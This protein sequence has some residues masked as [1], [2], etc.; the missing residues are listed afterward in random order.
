MTKD[1]TKPVILWFRKDL[2]LGDNKALDAAHL[3]GRPIIPFYIR[4]PE[5]AGT[6]PLGAAQCW[7]L[8]HSLDALDS[9]L[10]ERQGR[11][12]LAGG[13]AL[14]V[15]RA[16]IGTSGADAVFWNRRYDPAGMSIDIR[17]KHELEKQAIEVQS[18]GGQL[19]HEPSRLVTGGGTPY[20]VYT[21][22]WRALENAGEP[23]PPMDAPPKLHLAQELPASDMLDS[24]GLLPKKPD[25][26]R[27]FAD[28]WT[29]G[30]QGAREKLRAFVE[31]GLAGYKENRDHP[32]RDATSMLS[33]HLALG[34]I[35]PARIWDETRGLS[36]QVPAAD[37]VHFRKEIAWREFSYHLLFH[38]P[39]LASANWNDRFDGFEWRNDG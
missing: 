21:P 34:E 1:A 30:E 4:E 37:I 29:P 8:H 22:F 23:E 18:F 33:P 25:W 16:V 31:H 19:L 7:W 6:G 38:F 15:L 12:V 28:L 13:R 17:I 2:R 10:R 9:S 27:D 14:E 36:K 26:A 39:H 24:W 20:R 5:A 3:S 35:S 32:A 11:L